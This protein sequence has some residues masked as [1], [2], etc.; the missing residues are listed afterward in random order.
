[1]LNGKRCIF[2]EPWLLDR[3]G[4]GNSLLRDHLE[5]DWT[6]PFRYQWDVDAGEVKDS[7]C[8]KFIDSDIDIE[9]KF[10]K[11]YNIFRGQLEERHRS[12]A[13]S[14][15]QECFFEYSLDRSWC[16]RFCSYEF[17]TYAG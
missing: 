9:L 6:L 7:N 5:C 10:S 11:P 8:Q 2:D 13:L 3:N 17:L 15:R 1:M 4:S 14:L 12:D 16:D